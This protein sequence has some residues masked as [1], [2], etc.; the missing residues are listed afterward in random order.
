MVFVILPIVSLLTAALSAVIGM[1]GGT[2]LLAALLAFMTHSEAIPSHAAIQ[3]VSNSTRTVAFLRHVDWSAVRRFALGVVPGAAVGLGL[4]AYL[5]QPERSEPYL[6]MVVGA[7]ILL[8][9]LIPRGRKQTHRASWWDFPLLGLAAGVAGFTVGAVGPL[10]A[11]LFARR[12][13]VKERLVATKALCQTCVHIIK[14][15]GF[16]MVRSY[17]HLGQLGLLTLV[18]A[19]VAIPGTLLG[20][21]LHPHISEKHFVWLYRAAL[22][23][24][25]LKVLIVDGLLKGP[26]AG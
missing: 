6:K 15:P 4:L 3:L 11:P 18:L 20:R 21:R 14:I 13:F 19:A 9:L 22:L 24:A 17:E 1:G 7:Y 25:G 8:S 5:G 12:D 26:L 2:L 16:L 23:A 10:I